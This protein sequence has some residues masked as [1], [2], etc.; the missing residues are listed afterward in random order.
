ME[1]HITH[2]FI[3]VSNRFIYEKNS[4]SI[5]YIIIYKCTCYR[6]GIEDAEFNRIKGVIMVNHRIVQNFG[7]SKATISPYAQM[8]NSYQKRLGE[9]IKL[10]SLMIPAGSDYFLPKKVNKGILKEKENIILLDKLLDPRI[11]RVNAYDELLKHRNEYIYFYTDHHWTGL[12]A[13]YAYRAFAESAGIRPLE[14]SGMARVKKEK[15]FLGSLYNYT[16]DQALT[17]NPDYVEYYKIQ[18]KTRAMIYSD[19]SSRGRKVFF[20]RNLRIIMGCFWEG[21]L[22]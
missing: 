19:S 22:H 7:E 18:Q 11:I 1:V 20:M 2:S 13:Y 17:K 5:K 16:K 10:Y 21:I 3:S 8:L 15:M 14:L 6:W 9:H 4:F 12:G